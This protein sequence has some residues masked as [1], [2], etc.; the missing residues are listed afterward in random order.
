[1]ALTCLILDDEEICIRQLRRYV[2]KVPT[3][4]LKAYFTD[5]NESLMYL[6]KEKVDLIFV[7]MEMPN[8][9]VDGLDFVRIMGDSQRYIFTTAYP[10]YALPSYEYNVIDFLHKPYSF[11]RFMKAV[12]RAKEWLGTSLKEIAT[13]AGSY[14]Y[15]RWDGKLQRVDFD[16]ICWVESERNVIWFYTDT[17]RF[18]ATLTIGE[19]EARLPQ[20]HFI[21]VHKSY[22]I[23]INKAEVINKDTVCIRRHGKLQ[24]IPIGDTYKKDFIS[25]IENKILR[26]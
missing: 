12:Q 11:E 10:Q 5:P 25:S 15:V 4:A 19:I 13:E 7:D 26:K 20:N 21:R 8:Y 3:L 17:N 18:S 24:E 9:A 23:A 14:T 22:L 2:E 16:D 6:E 1:M